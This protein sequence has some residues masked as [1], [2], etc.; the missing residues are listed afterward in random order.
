MCFQYQKKQ[1]LNKILFDFRIA[2]LTYK[3]VIHFIDV[4]SL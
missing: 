4:D 1:K 3:T 2:S